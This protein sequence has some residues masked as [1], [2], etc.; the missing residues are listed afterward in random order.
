MR[1]LFDIALGKEIST[2]KSDDDS[3][4]TALGTNALSMDRR[5]TRIRKEAVVG[6]G[7]SD[8]NQ[9]NL[10]LTAH[11]G[12]PATTSYNRNFTSTFATATT[13][14]WRNYDDPTN[15][16]NH[17]LSINN[18]EYGMNE[19]IK[20]T[21]EGDDGNYTV[22]QSSPQHAPKHNGKK[23]EDDDD[24]I[25]IDGIYVNA[26]LNLCDNT[27]NDTIPTKE[28]DDRLCSTAITCWN[29]A[30]RARAFMMD[31]SIK[32]KPGNHDVT[33]F[34]KF[35][36]FEAYKE[37]HKDLIVRRKSTLGQ[38]AVTQR[39]RYKKGELETARIDLLESIG[40]RWVVRNQ[41]HSWEQ[42]FERL[43]LYKVKHKTTCVSPTTGKDVLRKWVYQQRT[44]YKIGTL[45]KDQIT[46]LESIGFR[47][48]VRFFVANERTDL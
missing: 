4:T 15:V 41:P 31:K 2:F 10:L 33:W 28:S 47:W 17:G 34:D 14:G 45:S 1:T 24:Y 16:S 27:I 19:T 11:H 38:W 44:R 5:N 37:K 35:L 46:R 9:H 20:M 7:R 12:S 43:V 18:N 25:C 26:N 48:A 23:D 21:E 40:F 32:C 6:N 3:H 29:S 30:H 42:Q 13:C 36:L 39:Q 22:V 8:T